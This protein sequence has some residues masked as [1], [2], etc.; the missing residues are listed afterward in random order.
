MLANTCS[1]DVTYKLRLE[2]RIRAL[3][4][5]YIYAKSKEDKVMYYAQVLKLRKQLEERN[6]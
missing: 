4:L 2:R 3:E 1:W 5:R 6:Q